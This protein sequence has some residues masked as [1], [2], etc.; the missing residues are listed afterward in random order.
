MTTPPCGF[1]RTSIAIG[2]IEAGRLVYFHN[3]G[4][5]GPGIY[6]PESWKTN[7][8]IFSKQG[9]TLEEAGLAETLEPLPAEG[10]YRVRESFTCCAKNCV[11]YEPDMLVQ[12]GYNGAAELILFVPHWHSDGLHLPD[13]GQKLDASR[14]GKLEPLK[15]GMPT[16]RASHD[17]LQ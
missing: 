10:F 4:E 5:P 13:K 1:Y 16:E 12:L 9:T 7:R 3:H 8:A 15:V 2:P 11:T 6:A 14:L 17:E